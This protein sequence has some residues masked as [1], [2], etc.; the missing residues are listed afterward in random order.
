MLKAKQISQLLT[1]TCRHG[2]SLCSYWTSQL[3]NLIQ[4]WTPLM[5]HCIYV[6]KPGCASVISVSSDLTQALAELSWVFG[7][8]MSSWQESANLSRAFS[9]FFWDF[10]LV[11]EML[12][13]DKAAAA[14][15]PDWDFL[16]FSSICKDRMKQYQLN[17]SSALKHISHDTIYQFFLPG[18]SFQSLLCQVLLLSSSPSF[19]ASSALC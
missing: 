9:Q 1:V 16:I 15:K 19:Q 6:L 18:L 17:N 2:D 5:S 12:S 11:T 13:R 10:D 4:I 8:N 14:P 7:D 3:I